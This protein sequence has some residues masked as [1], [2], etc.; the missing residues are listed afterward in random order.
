MCSAAIILV[1]CFQNVGYKF[2]VKF[3][4]LLKQLIVLNSFTFTHLI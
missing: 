1:L 2:D 3:V 4:T